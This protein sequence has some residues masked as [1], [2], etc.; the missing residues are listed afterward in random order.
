VINARKKELIMGLG[1]LVIGKCERGI[2]FD[3][4]IQ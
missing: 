2:A 4:L 1:E 3:C